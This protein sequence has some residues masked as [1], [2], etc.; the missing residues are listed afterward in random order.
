M[1]NPPFFMHTI[2][3]SLRWLNDVL[4]FM[5][6]VNRKRKS[7]KACR[8]TVLLTIELLADT[9]DRTVDRVIVKQRG[10]IA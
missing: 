7:S 5:E 8:L 1:L 9:R 10:K 4:H 3:F 2:L 6:A